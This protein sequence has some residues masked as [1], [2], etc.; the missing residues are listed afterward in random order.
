MSLV[1]KKGNYGFLFEFTVK[2]ADGT[3]F[4]LTGYTVTLKVWKDSTTQFTAACTITDAASGK[5]QYQ[6]TSG[7]FDAVGQ[8]LAELELTKTGFVEDTET[9]QITVTETAP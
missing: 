4:D 8:Y 5:C 1:V 7:D 2:K 6:V 3:A 9:F